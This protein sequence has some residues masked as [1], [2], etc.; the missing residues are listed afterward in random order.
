M[1]CLEHTGIYAYPVPDTLQQEEASTWLE[2]AS[3]IQRSLGVQRGK[4]DPLD[5]R[6]IVL[7]AYK[8]RQEVRLWG[9][10]SVAQ[11]REGRTTQGAAYPQR[12]IPNTLSRLRK[13]IKELQ[14]YGNPRIAK[15]I[16][17]FYQIAIEGEWEALA[18]IEAKI[19]ELIREDAQLNRL[20][21]L[22]TSV[23]GVNK[24][25][26]ARVIVDTNEFKN[27]KEGKAY[28]CYSAAAPFEHSAG[29]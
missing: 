4:S 18:A 23:D 21:Q 19:D 5:A 27:I 17:T 3:Q 28:A 6:R 11:K 1:F 20:Y 29:E 8:N 2:Q 25:I 12:K 15:R 14:S 7:D 26:A 22:I 10:T 16:E 13:P 9:A 24:C